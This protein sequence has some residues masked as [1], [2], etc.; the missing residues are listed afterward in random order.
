MELRP[1]IPYQNFHNTF[2]HTP[3]NNVAPLMDVLAMVMQAVIAKKIR[4]LTIFP[5]SGI[6]IN[7]S[8]QLVVSNCFRIEIN[9]NWF[10]LHVLISLQK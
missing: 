1:N 8:K 6:W 5:F 10:F 7:N 3:T 4:I 2:C 9:C